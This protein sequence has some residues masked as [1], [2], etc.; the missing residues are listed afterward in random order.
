MIF[1]VVEAEGGLVGIVDEILVEHINTG[2]VG[3][4][5]LWW[6]GCLVS[7]ADYGLFTS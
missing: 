1:G 6:N 2:V 3:Y 7:L 4:K 5:I